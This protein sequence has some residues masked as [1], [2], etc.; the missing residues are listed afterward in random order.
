MSD[1]TFS[2]RPLCTQD[3]HEYNRTA[4]AI[5]ACAGANERHQV[6][7][8]LMMWNEPN[9]DLE[10]SSLGIFTS[11][12]MLAAYVGLW[13]T[14]ETPVHPWVNW[15]VHPDFHQRC[16]DVELFI[17]AEER[18]LEV[19]KRCP[20]RSRF[21]LQT[22]TPVGYAFAESALIRAGY[23]AVRPSHEM[24]ITMSHRPTVPRLP[25]GMV[26]KPYLHEEDLPLSGENRA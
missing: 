14:A 16:L 7:D 11:Q 13:A 21:S 18:G 20:P 6:S 24:R 4:T 23:A 2:K 3:V 26:I 8:T 5:A 22:G 25:E 10:N 17:W 9:F 19:L 12:G 15:G 1:L